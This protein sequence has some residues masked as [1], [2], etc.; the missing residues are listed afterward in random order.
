ML[1]LLVAFLSG[2]LFVILLEVILLFGIHQWSPAVQKESEGDLRSDSSFRLPTELKQLLVSPGLTDVLKKKESC[3][4]LNL[5]LQ[6]VFQEIR[7]TRR[8]RGWLLRKLKIEFCELLSHFAASRLLQ[9]IRIVSLDVGCHLPVVKSSQV[10]NVQLSADEDSFEELELLLDIDYHGGF[11]LVL[12]LVSIIDT[13]A[14]LRVKVSRIS[15]EVRL[16]FTRNPFTHWS[17]TFTQEPRIDFDIDSKLRKRH[18]PQLV[19]LIINQFRRMFRKKHVLPAYR[20]RFEPFFSNPLYQPVSFASSEWLR[21]KIGGCLVVTSVHCTRL[22]IGDLPLGHS[23]MFLRFSISEK[24]V[25]VHASSDLPFALVLRLRKESAEVGTGILFRRSR[26]LKKAAR[27]V[28]ILEVS[29]DSPA[30]RCGLKPGD[31]LLSINNVIVRSDRQAIKLLSGNVAEYDLLVERILHDDTEDDG[32]S[33]SARKLPRVRSDLSPS[34]NLVAKER[35]RKSYSTSDLAAF[36]TAETEL[37]SASRSSIHA[38]RKRSHSVGHKYNLQKLRTGHSVR[39]TSE[40]V[41]DGKSVA[42]SALLDLPD[43]AN[44][45]RP[46]DVKECVSQFEKDSASAAVST[47]YTMDDSLVLPLSEKHACLTICLYTKP[48]LESEAVEPT[49]LCF[50]SLF[51]SDILRECSLTDSKVYSESFCFKPV[52]A[53]SVPLKLRSLSQQQ[54]FDPNLCYGDVR[55]VFRWYPSSTF[56]GLEQELRGD[57]EF[58]NLQTEAPSGPRETENSGGHQWANKQFQEPTLCLICLKKIWLRSALQ[59]TQCSTVIHKKCQSKVS[60]L[61]PCGHV[62]EAVATDGNEG[63]VEGSE[64]EQGIDASLYMEPEKPRRGNSAATIGRVVFSR[65]IVHTAVSKRWA[66]MRLKRGN[67]RLS[68]SKAKSSESKLASTSSATESLDAEAAAE[69]TLKTLAASDL[70][71]DKKDASQ[72]NVGPNVHNLLYTKTGTYNEHIIKAAKCMG[73]SLFADLPL[74]ERKEKINAQI[75]KLQAEINRANNARLDLLRKRK[76]SG[77]RGD[78]DVELQLEKLDETAQGL[79]VLM[80]HYCAGLQNCQEC[81]LEDAKVQEEEEEEEE[82]EGQEQEQGQAETEQSDNEGSSS[83]SERKALQLVNL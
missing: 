4:S 34:T 74:G 40:S 3:T 77:G 45:E 21:E 78:D 10:C 48:I 1:L 12:N 38:E 76:G 39:G 58:V 13:G 62:V 81:E 60:L 50:V 80:L 55:A 69:S 24:W 44:V 41:S 63:E 64:A 43:E 22:N 6:F 61:E 8:L 51:V 71:A 53:A 5:L 27:S 65:S 19:P 30:A 47:E 35:L 70:A 29:P 7:Q 82:E 17:F 83:G 15:G 32:E 67:V 9:D 73:K 14:C 18:L 52:A 59:C 31:V 23:E 37:D 36:P 72:E 28:E 46:A 20:I 2:I 26:P 25:S 54:G 56:E 66:S 57:R 75:D 68:K 42:Q 16:R 33:V 11:E 79:A 49:P